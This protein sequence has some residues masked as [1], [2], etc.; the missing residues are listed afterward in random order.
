MDGSDARILGNYQAR[1]DAIKKCFEV[2][3]ERGMKIFA[4]QHGGWCAASK[5][6]NGYQKYGKATNCANG[7]GG[8]WA[9]DVYL[10]T[11]PGKI[12]TFHGSDY[13]VF[14]FRM[15]WI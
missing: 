14:V 13:K 5:G 8:A 11:A 4:V 7:K 3:K 1:K 9:N 12:S 2:A 15:V 10:I 6:L